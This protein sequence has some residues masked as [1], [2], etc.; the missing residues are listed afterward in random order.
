[1]T[2]KSFLL[3]SRET[4]QHL[5]AVAAHQKL[6]LPVFDVASDGSMTQLSLIVEGTN[7]GSGV[8]LLNFE[9][10]D[11]T[12]DL[13]PRQQGS[14]VHDDPMP[15]T[16]P[17]SAD[18]PPVVVVVPPPPVVEAPV[19]SPPVAPPASD[20]I[21]PADTTQTQPPSADVTS[22]DDAFDLSEDAGDGESDAVG[23]KPVE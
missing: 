18:V 6:A 15:E 23:E 9:R 21:A 8:R 16:Q 11:G 13:E 2:H 3:I 12:P 14:E 22:L 17:E 7:D 10:V 4:L 5:A 20:T 1:M 19:E